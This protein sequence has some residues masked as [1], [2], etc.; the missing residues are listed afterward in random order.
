MDEAN[1][2]FKK[3][4]DVKISDRIIGFLGVLY[5]AILLIW[6]IFMI[7]Q[8][9]GTQGHYNYL[10]E[11]VDDTEI[12]IG[13]D[14]KDFQELVS[15]IQYKF[16]IYKSFFAFFGIVIILFG[17]FSLRLLTGT[18][19]ILNFILPG[20]NRKLFFLSMAGF[21][22]ILWLVAIWEHAMFTEIEE[23]LDRLSNCSGALDCLTYIDYTVYNT[24]SFITLIFNAMFL[25]VVGIIALFTRGPKQ[26]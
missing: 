22:I 19:K 5:S 4:S 18:E 16:M 12:L 20:E 9:N 8:I 21:I 26:S 25:F 7:G 2:E 11:D 23:E 15:L 6:I 17:L 24:W 10:A 1:V 13:E 14:R 3:G